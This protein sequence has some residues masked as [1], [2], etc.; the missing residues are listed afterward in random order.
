MINTNNVPSCLQVNNLCLMVCPPPPP[1]PSTDA[2]QLVN[3]HSS[4]K[5]KQKQKHPSS[6]RRQRKSRIVQWLGYWIFITYYHEYSKGPG[7]NP[8]AGICLYFLFLHSTLNYY[9]LNPVLTQR[10]CMDRYIVKEYWG[11]HPPTRL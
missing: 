5:S 2:F 10:L 4:N 3:T 1:E 6:R 9:R 11:P 8:G 7:S